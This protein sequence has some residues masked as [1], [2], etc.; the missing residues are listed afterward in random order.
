MLGK[1]ES[2][3]LA[4]D[5]EA[6]RTHPLAPNSLGTKHDSRTGLYKL[7]HGTDRPIDTSGT[8]RVHESVLARWDA[9]RSYRPANVRAWLV[10]EADPRAGRP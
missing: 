10:R 2:A 9:D 8:Q 7:V 6:E 4:M 5:L 3:G 1:A